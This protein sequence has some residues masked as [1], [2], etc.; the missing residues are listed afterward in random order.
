MTFKVGDNQYGRPHPSNSWA[1]CLLWC[2]VWYHT[3]VNVEIT[4]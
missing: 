4:C 1:C 2:V 3:C